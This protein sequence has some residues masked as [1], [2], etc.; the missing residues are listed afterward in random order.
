MRAINS[1]NTYHIYDNSVQLFNGL[2]AKVYGVDFDPMKGFSLYAHSDIVVTEKIYGVHEAKVVKVMSAFKSFGRSLGVIL[3]GDK[4]IGKSLFA[5]LLCGMAVKEGYPVIIVDSYHSGIA[6][7]LDSIDQEVV[8][9]FDEFDKTFR[10]SKDEDTPDVQAAMLSLFDGTSMNKKLFCVTCNETRNLNNFLVN[11]PGRFHYHFRFEYPT[12]EEI[13]VYMRDHLPENK[14][15]EI[16]KVVDFSRKVDL[17]Y[18]CLRAISY[19]LSHVSTFEEAISDLN[20]LKPDYG[21]SVN[22]F[23]LFD[24]GTRFSEH[25]TVD[26][27]SSDE[28]EWDVGEESDA[29]DNY[30]TIKFTPS[31]AVYTEQFGGYY[32]PAEHM[33]VSDMNNVSDNDS[34][35]MRNSRSFVEAHTAKNVTGIVIKPRFNR[36]SIHYFNV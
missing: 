11:R 1:G 30:L 35:V 7:F 24:D 23:I 22:M 18:D 6:H 9:L 34:W 33:K 27:F 16:S 14:H 36:K 2:P 13:E 31:D 32:L 5:K 4:G 28:E 15:S 12:A 17:N 26:M 29:R 10:K 21:Q 3:S 25:A 8:V 19:E 20:I